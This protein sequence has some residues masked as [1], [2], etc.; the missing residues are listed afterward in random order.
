MLGKLPENECELFRIRLKD[1]INPNHEL[2]L[3]AEEIDWQYFEKEF[4]I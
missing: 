3:L 1:L 4:S 2:T